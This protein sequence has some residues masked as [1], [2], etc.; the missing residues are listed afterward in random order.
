MDAMD[1][2]HVKYLLDKA[3]FRHNIPF[4]HPSVLG[5]IG[6]L[7]TIIPGKRSRPSSLV[8]E[9]TPKEVFPVLGATPGVIEY[10]SLKKLLNF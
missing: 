9:E 10:Y 7:I 2:Y 3:T 1:N 6:Q 5:L 4:A 8:Y